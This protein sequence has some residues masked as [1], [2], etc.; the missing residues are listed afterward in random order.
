MGQGKWA[1]SSY[2]CLLF[3]L[4]SKWEG[5]GMEAEKQLQANLEVQVQEVALGVL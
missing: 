3:N 1:Y 4:L 5:E 2:H